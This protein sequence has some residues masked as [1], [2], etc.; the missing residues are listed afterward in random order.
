MVGRPD[1]M[2]ITS[3]VEK[4]SSS[5]HRFQPKTGTDFV[6]FTEIIHM[7]EKTNSTNLNLNLAQNVCSTRVTESGRDF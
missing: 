3:T 4:F 2:V 6:I 1:L 5:F 7:N